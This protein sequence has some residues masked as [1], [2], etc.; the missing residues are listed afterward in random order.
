MGLA[1]YGAP[2]YAKLIRDH[3]LDLKPDGSFR[4][5]MTYF[6]YCE[7][8]QMASPAFDALFAGP[9]RDPESPITQRDMD[10][11]AS[12]QLVTEEI[13]LA[14]AR[15]V[16]AETGQTPVVRSASRSSSGIS[17]STSR[18]RRRTR[19]VSGAPCSARG[20]QATSWRHSWIGK[21][22]SITASTTS[23]PSANASPAWWPTSRW[24]GGFQGRME[25]GPRALGS[26][27]II[28]PTQPDHAVGDEPQNQ[29]PR[30][31]PSIRAI[32]VAGPGERILRHVRRARQSLHVAGR[33][34]AGVSA[35]ASHR[36]RVPRGT[37][38][39]AVAT[40]HRA[41]HHAR[42]LLGSCTDGRCRAPRAL[43][44]AAARLRTPDRMPHADQHEFQCPR[45]TDRVSA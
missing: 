43:S 13:M 14:A 37:C 40:V 21:G 16:H 22:R 44:R 18:D 19:I 30:V 3:L 42:R 33:A 28:G 31:V 36:R 24:W 29:V 23:R 6:Q 15:H 25:F 8:L 17:S 41:G 35:G 45:R 2:T 39:T 11:A 4:M 1:P 38:Q 5:N 27:S 12:I 32:G 9:R 34:G 26:R 10:I 7:G 20:L